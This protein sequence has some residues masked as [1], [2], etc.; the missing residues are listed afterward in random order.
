[1]DSTY[2]LKKTLGNLYPIILDDYNSDIYIKDS[3]PSMFMTSYDGIYPFEKLE[4][5]EKEIMLKI[6]I[7][8][9]ET[10][11]LHFVYRTEEDNWFLEWTDYSGELTKQAEE[12]LR[13]DGVLNEFK[14][15]TEKIYYSNE[16]QIPIDE[17]D[18]FDWI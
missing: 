3:L 16:E 5:L 4:F 7:G 9:G 2:V 17:F 14:P 18:Y 8:A 15:T 1:M 11:T 12:L 13:A 10:M 6:N